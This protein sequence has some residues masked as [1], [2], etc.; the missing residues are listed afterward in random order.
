MRFFRW[1]NGIDVSAYFILDLIFFE[2]P[3]QQN[4]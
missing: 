1:F 3:M 2:E 4:L